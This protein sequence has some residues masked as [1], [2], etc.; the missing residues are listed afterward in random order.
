MVFYYAQHNFVI[1][2]TSTHNRA[3]KSVQGGPGPEKNVHPLTPILIIKH[4]LSTFSI[5]YNP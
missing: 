4:P 5:S 2:Q 3:V 1:V